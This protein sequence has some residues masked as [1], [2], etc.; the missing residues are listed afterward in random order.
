M[1]KREIATRYLQKKTAQKEILEQ[2]LNGNNTDTSTISD[3]FTDLCFEFADP[4]NI[5]GFFELTGIKRYDWKAACCR[6]QKAL[7]ENDEI[8]IKELLHDAIN[9]INRKMRH[10]EAFLQTGSFKVE[11]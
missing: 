6:M 8:T 5:R 10:G 2:Y 7:C 9:K 3:L 11:D 4:D 1:D